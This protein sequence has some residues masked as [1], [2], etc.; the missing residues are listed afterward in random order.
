VSAYIYQ[1]AARATDYPS[2]VQALR[3]AGHRVVDGGI[4]NASPGRV[5]HILELGEAEHLA[6]K[7]H[8]IDVARYRDYVKR[9]GYH[10]RYREYY[11]GNQV[12]KSLEHFVGLTLLDVGRDDV[13]V[14][15][16]SEHSPVPDIYRALTGCTS[17]RQDIM[18]PAGVSGDRI[19]GDAA[20]MP[21]ADG[22]FTKA[23]LTCSLEHFEQDAD[24]RLFREL[25]RV[26]RPG[27]R[28]CVAPYY[29][30]V[31]AAVQTDPLM[32]VPA[33]VP[34][35]AGVVVHCAQGWNNRHGRFYSPHSFRERIV[36]AVAGKLRFDFFHFAN[37]HE[38]DPSVY[39][40]FAIVATRV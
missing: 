2:A 35:D 39:L 21:V 37:A 15:L 31:E 30:Y 22:F 4:D 23:T 19:G 14:D 36:D 29:C 5:R 40:R 32:S 17:Y 12:E 28:V 6:F 34:F 13:F 38:V 8:T 9:A 16:A 7:S 11:A 26:L 27:G 24:S 33:N 1:P 20:A 3:D 10:G 25:A 18:Y